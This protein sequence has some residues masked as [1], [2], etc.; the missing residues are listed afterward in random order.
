MRVTRRGGL[1][2]AGSVGMG[3]LGLACAHD[4]ASPATV[5]RPPEPPPPVV[6][7]P[8][9]TPPQYVLG[10]P[11]KA[12]PLTLVPVG[13]DAN[14]VIIE[15]HRFLMRAGTVTEARDVSEPPVQA[16]WAVPSRLG[17]GFLFKA[18]DALYASATFE[19]L[20][21]SVV[22]VPS[23][24]THV[25]FGPTAVLVR[26]ESGERW[27]LELSSG[28]RLPVA[29]AGLLDV[30]ALDDGR[31]A[32]LVEGGALMVST[33][34]GVHWTDAS[35]GVR[36]P[37]RRVLVDTPA[38]ATPGAEPA[39]W[40][41]TQ[42][43]QSARVMPG[44]RI[45][46]Y[47]GPVPNPT[48]ST[49]RAKQ[50]AWR[51]DEPPL[52]RA[53][54]AGVPF[55]EGAALVVASGDLVRVDL[56]TGAAEIVVAGKLPP[57]AACVAVRAP[58]DYLFTCGRPNG[59][60]FVVSH[61]LDRAPV[62]EQT[63]QEAGRFVVGDDGG[64]AFLGSCDK[65]TPRDR[66][67]AC[68]RAP[69]GTWQ[70][71]DPDAGADAGPGGLA[72]IRWIPRADGDAVA[73]VGNI[74]GVGSAWGLVDGRTGQV[75]AWGTEAFSPALT[76]ALGTSNDSRGGGPWDA[77]RLADRAWT[78]T[79]Q[80]TLR[81][82]ANLQ[83]GVG[84]V[85]VGVDGSLQ[86]SPFTFDRVAAAGPLALARL[87][88]GRVWQTSDRGFTWSEVAAPTAF[89]PG[90]WLD[91]HA[92]SVVG[93]D[94]GQWYRIGWAATAPVVLPATTSAQPPPLVAR[95]AVPTLTCK[96]TSDAKR[97]A[98]NR[99][100][101]SPEDFGLGAVRVAVSDAAGRTEFVRLPFGRRVA[102]SVRD[103]DASSEGALRALV[104]GPATEPGDDRLFVH[105]FDR[106]VMSLVRQV[107]FVGA[108]DPLGAIRRAPLAMTDVV[109]AEHAAGVAVA[110]ALRN[111][112]IPSGVVPV[113]PV[114]PT[115]P[116]DLL[117]QIADGGTALLRSGTRAARP[118]LAYEP[119]RGDDQRIVGAVEL[120]GAV[121]WLE[122]DASGQARVMRLGSSSLPSVA[123][124]I[125]APPSAELYPANVDAL[126][127]GPRG[128]LAILRTPSGSEP[129][130][131]LDPAVLVMPN[132]SAVPL[133][134]WSTV[135]SAD[136]PTCKSDAGG[137]RATVQAVAPW[138]R[139][140]GGSDFASPPDA[141]M[142][143]R[144]RWS[145]QRVCL[146]GVEV[147]AADVSGAAPS[148]S[149]YGSVWDQAL[150]TWV[151]ARFAGGASAGRVLVVPGAELR[152]PLDCAITP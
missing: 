141:T 45:A 140:A 93:C 40:I 44:G 22:T 135:V 82:W 133:A 53:V 17:G 13:P 88:D 41:E 145:D 21:R 10:D 84:A 120:D 67:L 15:G 131:A 142:L 79:P 12:T 25:S 32:A 118:R 94:L 28:K 122:E 125:D 112:P 102:G 5:A 137:W 54:H 109:A 3:V 129:P 73:V 136:D 126:A 50:D 61:A 70:Q 4:G 64:L 150:E 110:D 128:E 144:V 16:A 36:S 42:A 104:H 114:D 1:A 9:A 30:A 105:G 81:G 146:E 55:G 113:T 2:V 37:A 124:S 108:F 121:A 106:D 96:A 62:V 91:P 76:T 151:V 99:G 19:G 83:G 80:G 100:E 111:D 29:P 23:A 68:V 92:C 87:K 90:A 149:Q 59:A 27:M 78:V 18:H 139:L 66:R 47:D 33:D 85:E 52:R 134:P 31:A 48:P 119:G 138:L 56:S 46:E 107:S 77:G 75:H 97:A 74:G 152:Q 8:P 35:Q 117:V 34:G 38:D 116:D 147:R 95:A 57:D 103:T 89:H 63:F 24:I 130:S 127:V 123:F 69:G 148:T 101:R 86:T 6:V 98:S 132:A 143:A 51:E 49:L 43:G 115:A 71:F 20:L 58:D 72:L 60:A 11:P 39:L 65:P 7:A 26:A 14:G